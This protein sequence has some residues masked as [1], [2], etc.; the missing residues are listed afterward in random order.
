MNSQQQFLESASASGC[1]QDEL[2]TDNNELDYLSTDI[3]RAG[4]SPV[5]GV[6]PAST[7][8]LAAAIK[9]ANTCKLKVVPRGGGASYSDG[10]VTQ[11]HEYILLDLRDLSDITIDDTNA[12]VTVGAGV[13]WA[14]L[15]TSLDAEGWRT[16][17]WGPF[18]GIAA[19][20]GGSMSQNAISH[21][22]GGY[23]ISADSV[24]GMDIVL[25]NGEILTTGAAAAGGA[26]GVRHF[27]PDLT[28]LFTGDCG[29]L[30][31]KASITL[32]LIRSK[33]YFRAAS[34]TFTDFNSLHAGMRASSLE[35]LDD[36]NFALD[37]ALSQGQLGKEENA[38]RYL[39]VITTVIKTHGFVRG[40]PQ[41]F[42]MVF[43][44]RQT[45]KKIKFAC[46][47]IIDGYSD[48]EV[49]AKLSRLREILSAHGNEIMNTVPSVV[50]GM[51]FAPLFNTLGL[52]GER[53]VPLHGVMSHRQ[54]PL[55]HA[56]L[57]KFYDQRKEE[58][59]RYGIWTGGMFTSVGSSGFLYEIAIYWPD[60]RSVYH[61]RVV[62][63]E[64]LASL[65]VYEDNPEAREYVAQLKSD[66]I[67]LY[68]EHSASFFQIGR[69]YDYQQRLNPAA[70]K[71]LADIKT[72]LDKEGMINPGVIGLD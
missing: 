28:G 18:S 72:S 47:Y 33:P 41:L 44:A 37:A 9:A 42:K 17:F 22:S 24:V 68:V 1:K 11:G 2:I 67:K 69:A 5:A 50:R 61:E 66:L 8:S 57:E 30:G 56:A 48:A 3:Y 38:G 71:L 54:T 27:G 14:Q 58:M 60:A 53:W 21:G 55:F 39:E 16:P 20:V 49:K 52:A 32:P 62:D 43:G 31:I 46:H 15:K 64:Y 63:P 45:I 23:G 59:D 6:R 25:A 12:V 34:F 70:A 7:S 35:G 36:E 13:T 51:P 65:P 29:A 19:T 10:Y 4:D 40:L 26:A